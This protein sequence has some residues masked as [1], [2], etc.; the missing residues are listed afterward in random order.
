MHCRF[1][2]IEFVDKECV[3]KAIKLDDSVFKGRQLKVTNFEH[4]ICCV[5]GSYLVL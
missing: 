2:Y 1:A 3:D 5:I 4:C